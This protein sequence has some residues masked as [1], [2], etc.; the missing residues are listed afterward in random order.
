MEGNDIL[1]GEAMG[2]IQEIIGTLQG[3]NK[4]QQEQT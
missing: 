3:K 4:K 1:I 2:K